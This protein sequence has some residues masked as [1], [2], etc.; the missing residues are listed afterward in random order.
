MN[1]IPLKGFFKKELTQALRDKRMR[2]L[3]FALPAI[4]MTVFGF[5]LKAEVR[6][7]RLA[8]TG[9]P[10]DAVLERI[11]RR[12]Y[13]S[14]YFVPADA[15]GDWLAALRS[16]KA[17]AVLS[18][19]VE[20]RLAER[21][22]KDSA[23]LQLLLDA[24]NMQR[25][26]QVEGYMTQLVS[27]E[28]AAYQVQSQQ[29]HPPMSVRVLYNPAQDSAI[30]MVPAVMCLVLCVIT[31]ILTAMALAREKETGTFETII[32][33]PLSNGEILAGKTLP[34]ILIG[35][36]DVPIV[37]LVAEGVFRVPIR[38]PLWEL[39]LAAAVFVFSTVAVGTVISTFSKNQQQAMMASFLFMFPA[40]LLSGT[41]FPVENIPPAFKAL[42]YLNPLKYFVTLLRG[43]MFKDMGLQNFAFNLLCMALL[44]GAAVVAA[45]LRFRQK[46][47]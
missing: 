46:L 35:L 17:E 30:F 1:L 7:V 24:S 41:M 28:L 43:I 19:P 44:S 39:A 25:A 31:I 20:G 14:G 12:A 27:R 45:V 3:I 13:A 22:G 34:Y 36:M 10:G 6:N 21:L 38:G 29:Q 32:S 16:G 26:Q 40:I 33:A 2:L 9:K 42:A 4:Q 11:A 47:N 23:P 18:G 37:L 8:V 5:A 15:G